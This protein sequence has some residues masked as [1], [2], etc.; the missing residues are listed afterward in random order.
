MFLYSCHCYPGSFPY[1]PQF[2]S[3]QPALQFAPCAAPQTSTKPY[4][5]S[6]PN[7]GVVHS[8]P[9]ICTL[10]PQVLPP[11]CLAAQPCHCQSNSWVT[12]SW[13]LCVAGTFLKSMIPKC[14][15]CVLPVEQTFSECSAAAQTMHLRLC[16]TPRAEVMALKATKLF[17]H[18]NNNFHHCFDRLGLTPFTYQPCRLSPQCL[19]LSPAVFNRKCPNLETGLSHAHHR[20][21]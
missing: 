1:G 3:L 19:N 7:P 9:L 4:S 18:I 11:S 21:K 14:L 2:T 8:L 15:V 6:L 17:T 20:G 12:G 5:T 10:S 16:I 13:E